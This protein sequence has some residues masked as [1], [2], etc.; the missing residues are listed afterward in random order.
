MKTENTG[1]NSK[2]SVIRLPLKDVHFFTQ[3]LSHRLLRR[4][5]TNLCS[6]TCM[7]TIVDT[8]DIISI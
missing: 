6:V 7:R 8:V 2:H 4:M 5:L 1:R 3:Q